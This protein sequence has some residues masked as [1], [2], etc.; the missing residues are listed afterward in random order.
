MGGTFSSPLHLSSPI[1]PHSLDSS[2]ISGFGRPWVQHRNEMIINKTKA[3]GIS[4]LLGVLYVA[5]CLDRSHTYIYYP[6]VPSVLFLWFCLCKCHSCG[7]GWVGWSGSCV[8]PG[9]PP[10]VSQQFFSWF[11][12]APPD[13]SSLFRH[14][15]GFVPDVLNKYICTAWISLN[16]T[17]AHAPFPGVLHTGESVLTGSF[18]SPPVSL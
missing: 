14:L 17:R 8:V 7:V 16:V 10:G 12:L 2:F 1:F 11:A 18:H 4:A 3:H 6:H 9:L 5:S 13:C 15:P